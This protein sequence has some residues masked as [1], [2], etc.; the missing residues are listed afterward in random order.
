VALDFSGMKII[1]AHGGRGFWYN[2][3]FGIARLQKNVYIEVSGL[4]PKKLIEFLPV[5]YNLQNSTI[6]AK[7]MVEYL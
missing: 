5:D 2:E 6:L 1:L 7:G 3:A 4:P